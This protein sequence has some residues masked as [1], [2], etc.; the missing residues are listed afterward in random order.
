MVARY[1]RSETAKD[2]RY[3][4]IELICRSVSDFLD[5]ARSYYESVED[6]KKRERFADA[7]RSAKQEMERSCDRVKRCLVKIGS[8]VT[9][10]VCEFVGIDPYEN[11]LSSQARILAKERLRL[12]TKLERARDRMRRDFIE[13]LL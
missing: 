7:A 9:E 11:R 4:E 13:L 10:A 12:E 3:E 5:E 2:V 1:C 8:S 6:P